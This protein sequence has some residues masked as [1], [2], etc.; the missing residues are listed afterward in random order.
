MDLAFVL[1]V[2]DIVSRVHC[3]VLL[4]VRSNVYVSE[5][6]NLT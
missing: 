1:I 6:T 5:E 4:G 3:I 2:K